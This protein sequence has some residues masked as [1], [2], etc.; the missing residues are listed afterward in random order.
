M[1]RSFFTDILTHIIK[2]LV[3]H[4]GASLRYLFNH[5]TPGKYYSY[6]AFTRNAPLLDHSDRPYREAFNEWKQQQDERNRY[7]STRLNA[8]QLHILEVLKAEG[9]THEE[10]IERMISAGDI[11][12][13]NTDIFPHSPEYFSNRALNILIGV[14]FWLAILLY[15]CLS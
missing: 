7:A 2:L 3:L 14:F 11:C 4:T 13:L 9:C 1:L 6:H 10:A 12:I 8:K 5:F 15:L